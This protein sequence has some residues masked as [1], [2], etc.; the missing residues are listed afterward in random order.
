MSYRS[1]KRICKKKKRDREIR[2]K[3]TSA[4]PSC[5]GNRRPQTNRSP[6]HSLGTYLVDQIRNRPFPILYNRLA[7]VSKL[8]TSFDD[9]T[10]VST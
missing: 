2:R 7:H 3:E 1:H 9:V 5:N 8:M 6:L 4:T 10:T